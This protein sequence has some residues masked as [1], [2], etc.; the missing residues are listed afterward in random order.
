MVLTAAN[1]DTVEIVYSGT[2]PF[3]V[4]GQPSTIIADT[5]FEIVDGTG[6]FA[7]AFGGGEMTAYISFPGDF[8]PANYPWRATWYWSGTIDY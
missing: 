3:P 5:S 1:G 6:R 4:P 2:A 7:G 8:D